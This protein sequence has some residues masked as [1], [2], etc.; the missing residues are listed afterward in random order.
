MK[1]FTIDARA[2]L[3][4]G[5]DSIKDHTTALIELVKNSYDA[6]A[7]NVLIEI[8]CKGSKKFIR[9]ADNGCGMDEDTVDKKWLRIGY[10]D[11]RVDKFSKMSRRKTGEKGIGRISADRLGSILMLKTKSAQSNVFGLSVNWDDFNVEGKDLSSIAIKTLDAPII[12]LPSKN[13]ITGTEL[14][15]E[16]LRQRWT[17]G[18]IEN[19]YN[20]LS[21]LTPPFEKVEDFEITLRTDVTNEFNGKIKSPFYQAAEIELTAEIKG[22]TIAYSIKGRDSDQGEKKQREEI[23]WNELLQVLQGTNDKSDSYKSPTFGPTKVKLLFY[24]RKESSVLEGTALRLSDLREFLDKNVGVKIYRDGIRVKPYGN[25]DDSEGDWLGLA[26]RKTR[27]PAGIARP[28]WRVGANQLVGAVFVGRDSNPHL[29]DSS[30]REGLIQG[31]SF[32]QLRAFVMGCLRLLE[33]Y[34]HKVVSEKEKS[35]AQKASPSEDMT[36][37]HKELTVL[38][39]DLVEMKTKMPNAS[40]KPVNRALD[41][42]TTVTEKIKKTE[43]SLEELVSQTRVLRGLATIGI[44]SA[45]F[46]H[47]TQ[48]SMSEFIV[49]T[50]AAGRLLAKDPPKLAIALEE[51]EKAK[52]YAKQV[53]AW[54]AF[55]LTRVQRDKRRRKRINIS[56]VISDTI[57]DV[58]AVFKG[59]NIDIEPYLPTVEGRTFAMDIEAILLNLLTNAYTAC[60]Q[61]GRVRKISVSIK[62]SKVKDIK[63]VEM[64]VADSGPGINSK[65]I[66]RI[67]DPLFTTKVDKEGKE[68]GTGLGLSIVNSIVD[69]LKGTKAVDSDPGLGGARF[70][71]WIPII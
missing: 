47:E 39:K 67:W 40:S 16:K 49:A 2:I 33:T 23:K 51:I 43:K 15:I 11:K 53:S 42:V 24:P 9:I 21:I 64:I 70:K 32:N 4:L 44:A 6:D 36:V 50:N 55:A 1:K 58:D 66:S 10:S 8:F 41:Q 52:K 68:I 14:T 28:T 56:K 61:K 7:T 5:R 63:G 54:G 57:K 37:L 30:S 25:P 65:F 3:T 71:I 19:L 12:K 48:S 38:K 20:E 34:R 31:E 27:D 35:T 59:S 13:A 45:V 62:E 17:I 69:D 29:V 18:D 60:Q 46:G 26:E 22:E